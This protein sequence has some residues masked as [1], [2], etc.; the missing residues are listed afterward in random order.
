MKNQTIL[1]YPVT[2][3]DSMKQPEH[4]HYGYLLQAVEDRKV[5]GFRTAW[6]ECEADRQG[7]L[8][9]AVTEAAGRITDNTP[10]VV[11]MSDNKPVLDGILHLHGWEQ[12]GWK[13]SRGRKIQREEEWKAASKA[14][15]NKRIAAQR[16]DTK[17]MEYLMR[18]IREK[19]A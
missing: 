2:D 10:G 9:K 14:L 16:K 13:R 19:E 4:G 3:I 17:T 7:A 8:I 18:Q 1:I 15:E 5:K 12:N 11:I 6:E